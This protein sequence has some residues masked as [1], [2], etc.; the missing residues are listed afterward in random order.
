MLKTFDIIMIMVIIC[1]A[2]TTF[3]I[4]SDSR[5]Q[6]DHVRLLE[7]QIA[8]E[9]ETI[10]LLEADW[11]LLTQP[12]RIQ[13]MVDSHNSQL[14]LQPTL[15]KQISEVQS[16]PEKNMPIDHIADVIAVTEDLKSVEVKTQTGSISE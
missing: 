10:D 15:G 2:A 5:D 12:S 7:R 11:S 8:H 4:K 14:A 3:K 16:I 1:A 9:E 6:L 13:R